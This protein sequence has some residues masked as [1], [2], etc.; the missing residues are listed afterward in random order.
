MPIVHRRHLPIVL[1]PPRKIVANLEVLNP[2]TGCFELALG[3]PNIRSTLPSFDLDACVRDDG[4]VLLA[5]FDPLEQLS[6]DL[7]KFG[8]PDAD[9]RTDLSARDSV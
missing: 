8:R 3:Q 7:R 1:G 4:A 5:L 9:G 2:T 6:F